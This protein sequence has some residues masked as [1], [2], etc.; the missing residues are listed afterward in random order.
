MT[1]DVSG[2]FFSKHQKKFREAICTSPSSIFHY[3]S[4]TALISILQS[5]KLW[6]SNIKFLNDET[7]NKQIFKVLNSYIESQ[8]DKFNKNYYDSIKILCEQMLDEYD[9]FD[10]LLSGD[11][12]TYVA[13]FSTESDQL[14]L[15]NYYTKNPNSIGYNIEFNPKDFAKFSCHG[16]SLNY[17]GQVIYSEEKQLSLLIP[18]INDFHDKYLT[19]SEQSYKEMLIQELAAILCEFSIFFKLKDFEQESEYRFVWKTSKKAEIRECRNFFVS[20]VEYSL[21]ITSIK[22]IGISPTQKDKIVELG[23]RELLNNYVYEEDF[24]QITIKLSNIPV[25]Y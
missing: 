10:Y 15:W 14:N 2:E 9:I 5:K 4:S 6:F 22:S 3:T 8:K 16:K 25:R 13:S 17:S 7:E 23:L 12:N 21:P 24:D 18:L 11:K 20:Y 19:I 1:I